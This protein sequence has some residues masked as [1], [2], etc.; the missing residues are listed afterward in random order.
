MDRVTAQRDV[1]WYV[2]VDDD[3]DDDDDGIACASQPT[4]DTAEHA[5]AA[6]DRA[7][8]ACTS[9]ATSHAVADRLTSC[10]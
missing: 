8:I 2:V 5:N 7:A 1:G 6:R 9:A 3:D 10:W 4:S